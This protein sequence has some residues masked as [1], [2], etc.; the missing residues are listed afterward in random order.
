MKF[1]AAVVGALAFATTAVAAPGTA[2]RRARAAERMASRGNTKHSNI[3]LAANSFT[4]PLHS[5]GSDNTTHP[6]YSSNWAGAVLIGSGYT[7]VTGIITVPTPKVPSGGSTRT[8]YAASAWV[9][10]DGD[11]CQTAILQTGVDFFIQGSTVSFDAWYEWYP[12]KH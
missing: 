4:E 6:Q 2:M 5:E 10:L 9:G 1:S 8:Q 11:T 12:G 7:S 3:A